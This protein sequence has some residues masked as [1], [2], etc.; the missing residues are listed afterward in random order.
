MQSIVDWLLNFR[1]QAGEFIIPILPAFKIASI[2]ISALLLWGIIYSIVKSRWLI[3]RMD[4]LTDIL[5][6]GDLL[7]IRSLRGW[8]KIQKN[9]KSDKVEDWKSAIFDAD[10]IL[11]DVIKASGVQGETVDERFNQLA[12]EIISNANQVKEAHQ[13]KK[14]IKDNPESVLRKEDALAAVFIYQ[15]AFEDLKLID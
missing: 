10:K 4:R 7:R 14:R 11:D 6:A 9:I 1:E 8:K 15:K 5:G 2:I 12:P 13:I 3:D